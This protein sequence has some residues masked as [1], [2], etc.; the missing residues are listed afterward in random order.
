M[1]IATANGG[2]V[3]SD[4]VL[5]SI[6]PKDPWRHEGYPRS[7]TYSTLDRSKT[8]SGVLRIDKSGVGM[9][10]ATANDY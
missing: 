4:H 8:F 6:C 7:G 1:G 9:N 5:Q 2:L 10:V 3:D